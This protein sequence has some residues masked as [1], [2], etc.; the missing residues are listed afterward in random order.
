MYCKRQ[1]F[2]AQKRNLTDLQ[3]IYWKYYLIMVNYYSYFVT[4]LYYFFNYGEYEYLM[5]DVEK[6]LLL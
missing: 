2:V 3:N 6:L 4:V 1:D 5:M